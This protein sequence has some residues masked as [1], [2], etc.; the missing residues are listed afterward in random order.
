MTI[1][2]TTSQAFFEEKYRRSTDPW[3]FATSAYEQQRYSTILNAIRHRHYNHAFEPGCS[4]G[5][6]T[7]QLATFCDRVDATD[8]ALSAVAQTRRRTQRLPNVQTTC[9]AL[10]ALIPDGTFDLIVFSEIGYYFTE[11]ALFSL[12]K[13]LVNRNCKS[14]VFLAAHWLGESP[15]HLLSGDRVHEVLAQVP[16]LSLQHAERHPG[17]RLDLWTRT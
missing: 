4:V 5:V 16:D 14:G 9:G 10:P 2:N 12:A 15:D 6:L 8:I 3:D 1:E 11:K 17:F 13:E 7:E